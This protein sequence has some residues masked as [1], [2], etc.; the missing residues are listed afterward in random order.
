MWLWGGIGH[1][2]VAFELAIKLRFRVSGLGWQILST[3]AAQEAR[4]WKF[5]LEASCLEVYKEN[6]RDLLL[7][8]PKDA[9]D[10][11]LDIKHTDDG[12]TIVTDLKSE[13]VSSAADVTMLM[14]RAAKIR[15]T[16]RTDM[17]HNSSRSHSVFWLKIFG[18]H[19]EA[20]QEVRI[21]L[22]FRFAWGCGA[23]ALR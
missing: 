22:R 15:S 6:V 21:A 3:T 1:Q 12:G 2:N 10:K 13:E 20:H 23:S 5:R 9:S 16:A 19:A 14:D 18:T 17:N 11:K 7:L 8:D 4:G